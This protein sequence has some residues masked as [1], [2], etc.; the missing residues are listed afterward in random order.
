MTLI[1]KRP[2]GAG[3]ILKRPVG[4]RLEFTPTN[5]LPDDPD[6][7]AYIAAVEAVDGQAL[8]PATKLALNAFFKGCKVDGTWPALK[9]CCLMVGARTLAGA[10]VPLVGPAPTNF[11]F[12]AE[13]Y[14]RKTG[15]KNPSGTRYLNTNF[16]DDLLSMFSKHYCVRLSEPSTN[17]GFVI[18]VGVTSPTTITHQIQIFTNITGGN[19]VSSGFDGTATTGFI[20]FSRNGS[21]A[22]LRAASQNFTSTFSPQQSIG[23]PY[24]VNTRNLNGGLS[25]VSVPPRICYYSIGESLNLALLDARVSALMAALAAAI[26]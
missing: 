16:N 19:V 10:L 25:G 11:N 6:A 4:A 14:G 17:G 13:L 23:L 1:L 15:L 21:N 12:V 18:G 22:T 9:A 5:L 2:A 8:E 3:L 20:G 26:P 7:M 24:F